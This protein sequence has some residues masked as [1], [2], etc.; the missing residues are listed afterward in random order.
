MNPT[1]SEQNGH[2]LNVFLNK[3]DPKSNKVSI[4]LNKRRINRVSTSNPL[5]LRKKPFEL[6]NKY[7]DPTLRVNQKTKMFLKAFWTS[8]ISE[9]ENIY[10]SQL[11]LL[12]YFTAEKCS[13][14]SC[15]FW[16]L[17]VD[18]A[19]FDVLTYNRNLKVEK[20]GTETNLLWPFFT[21]ILISQIPLLKTR[22][23]SVPFILC[24]MVLFFIYEFPITAPSYF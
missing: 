7:I 12:H 6:Y 19:M 1:E 20:D 4:C 11:S 23:C 15:H 2:S 13:I 21:K 18:K 8:K 24:I 10:I 16:W 9:H 22:N 17:H 5:K 3:N 14:S